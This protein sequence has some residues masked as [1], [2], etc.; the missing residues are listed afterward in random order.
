MATNLH[1]GHGSNSTESSYGGNKDSPGIENYNSNLNDTHIG[2]ASNE[3]FRKRTSKGVAE[4]GGEG[5]AD[6]NG[7]VKKRR[8][9]AI[10]SCAF[11][12]KRKLRCD[13]QKPMCSTCKARNHKECVYNTGFEN[14]LDN[15]GSSCSGS[16]GVSKLG[17]AGIPCGAVAG[18]ARTTSDGGFND[19]G[20][21]GSV[22]RKEKSESIMEST[23]PLMER[24]NQL[25]K[26]LEDNG[27][28]VKESVLSANSGTNIPT[29]S[30]EESA[31]IDHYR[32]KDSFEVS[33]Y[34]QSSFGNRKTD[35]V[36]LTRSQL[37]E[38][39]N[40]NILKD[41]FT[42]QCKESGR[43][44]LYG[45]TSTRI[46]IAKGKWAMLDKFRQVWLKVKAARAKWK[47]ETNYTMLKEM[48]CVEQPLEKPRN[49][50]NSDCGSDCGINSEINLK[51]LVCSCL[52]TFEKIDSLIDFF[53]SNDTLFEA[54]D[55]LDKFK[56]KNDFKSAFIPG[57]PSPNLNHER[58]II[59]LVANEKKN[60]YKI[61]VVLMILATTHYQSELPTEIENFSVHLSGLST[62][63]ALYIERV[64]F[65][66]VKFHYRLKYGFTGGDG[67]HNML[68][69]DDAIASSTAIGLNRNIK[70]LYK[71]Q[72]SVVGSL[73]TLQKLWLWILFADCDISIQIGRPLRISD[74]EIDDSV[75]LN[76]DSSRTFYDTFKRFIL[77]TR[78][79]L[80]DIHNKDKK[81]PLGDHC[82]TLIN[83]IENE[84]P[85]LSEFTGKSL[86]TIIHLRKARLLAQTVSL[87]ITF[88]CLRYLA[89][90]EIG[91]GLKNGVV[92]ASLISFSLYVNILLYSFE[93]DK[94]IFPERLDPNYKFVPPYLCHSFSIVHGLPFRAII[95][96]Y[97]LAYNSL[98]LF[99]SGLMCSK[100]NLQTTECDLS[101]LRVQNE[102]YISFLTFFKLFLETFDRL[103]GPHN[104]QFGII[105]RRSHVFV[106][107]AAFERVCRKVIEK[108]MEC[109]TNAENNWINE[110]KNQQPNSD[111][112]SFE[113]FKK[114][115]ELQQNIKKFQSDI[116]NSLNM[117]I[118][119]TADYITALP[120]MNINSD[121]NCNT[122]KSPTAQIAQA[123][124]T[125]QAPQPGPALSL[126]LS[127]S[128]Q[129][130]IAQTISDDFWQS[131]NVGWQEI[132]D[133]AEYD[134]FFQELIL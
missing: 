35:Y 105:A 114:T 46:F 39:T 16:G 77:M 57:E 29:N 65:L 11:C 79:M 30:T 125:A 64:Q 72:E 99:E 74:D 130:D 98:T 100:K 41:Y 34:N 9:K 45:P 19:E 93:L 68:V 26:Q 133:N 82:E 1:S 123:T 116:D 38:N 109:R 8:R 131:Y 12:R 91:I 44:I 113:S 67:S 3:V 37:H 18:T 55:V 58:P 117:N 49:F 129:E 111:Y 86:T 47:K 103:M 107:G 33:I 127:L 52:P 118:L 89:F 36:T 13:Q 126:S 14:E 121:N 24:L 62:A 27:T 70:I 59:A 42:L 122:D 54:S 90:N 128:E 4:T 31:P 25:Q 120:S 20:G 10:K 87:L 101:T 88:Y 63:K 32:S 104:Q 78:R 51:S 53:F 40:G 81:P 84:F 76:N 2:A 102:S 50:G 73:E 17:G 23:I 85:P 15:S 66:V 7:T 95:V 134:N 119:D 69:I 94:K 5:S 96:F 80:S 108:V 56:V 110:S 92:K 61:G 97:S 21:N 106:I 132:L 115:N 75:F 71:G 48:K 6:G 43:R 60:Y 112:A 28:I 22:Y 83:F 124:E